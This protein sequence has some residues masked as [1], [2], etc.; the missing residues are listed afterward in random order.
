VANRWTREIRQF[1]F[2]W[3]HRH[4]NILLRSWSNLRL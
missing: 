2:G 4:N 3:V 1:N